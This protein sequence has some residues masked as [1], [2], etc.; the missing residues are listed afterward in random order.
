MQF[1]SREYELKNNVVLENVA[2]DKVAEEPI[3]RKLL[4]KFR[5]ISLPNW[6]IVDGM[7]PD[8]KLLF[9]YKYPIIV[10]EPIPES[11]MPFKALFCMLR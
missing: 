4:L 6:L 3:V 11:I 2:D 9:K 5:K 10:S 7:V 8:N 1:P